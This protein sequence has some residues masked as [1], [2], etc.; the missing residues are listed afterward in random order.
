LQER[1]HKQQELQQQLNEKQQ[2]LDRLVS[3][4]AY[5]MCATFVATAKC[6]V[7]VLPWQY[8]CVYMCFCGV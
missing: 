8:L 5:F 2:E 3:A 1:R 4:A 6:M 7:C